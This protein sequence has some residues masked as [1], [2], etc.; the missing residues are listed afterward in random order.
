MLYD[1]KWEQ[2]TRADPFKL[3]GLIAWLENQ[4]P[5]RRYE[6]YDCHGGCL[7]GIYSADVGVDM[8][9]CHDAFWRRGKGQGELHEIAK[10]KPWTMGAALNRARDYLSQS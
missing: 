4:S 9:E 1:P 5:G 8:S 3:E 7:I 10:P 6:Y 2:K